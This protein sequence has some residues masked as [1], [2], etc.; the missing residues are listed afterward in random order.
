[1][2]CTIPFLFHESIPGILDE[3]YRPF[4]M[5]VWTKILVP[6]GR[7]AQCTEMTALELFGIYLEKI[8]P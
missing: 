3:K 8:V 5:T 1:M 6:G 2:K 7:E 4:G